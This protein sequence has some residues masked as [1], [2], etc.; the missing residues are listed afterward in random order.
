LKSHPEFDGRGVVIAILDT[1]VDPGAIGLQITSENKPKIIDIYDCSGSGDVDIT[2]VAEIKESSEGKIEIKGLT[3]R[4]LA[5]NPAWAALNPGGS[6]RVGVKRLFELYPKPLLRRVKEER[7]KDWDA[8]QHAAKAQCRT[9]LVALESDAAAPAGN[10]TPRALAQRRKALED[11]KETLA[12]LEAADKDYDDPGPISDCVAWRDGEGQWW[13][14]VDTSCA[15][16]LSQAEAMTNYRTLRQYRSFDDLA[17]LN[18]CLNFWDDGKVMS[19][20]ADA[21][22]HGTHVAGITAGYFP[23]QPELNGIAPGAQLVSL[24]IGDS[25]LGS[26]ETGVGLM[27][28]LIY[29]QKLKVDLINMSYG[30]AACV[31]NSG[32]FVRLSEE[33]VNKH[34][35]MY[36]CSAGNNGPALTTVG[37]PGGTSSAMIGVGAYVAPSMMRDAYSMRQLVQGCNYTW[38]SVGPAIDGDWGVNLMAPGG[39]IAPICN[40]TLSKSGLKNGTSMSSPNAC[41]NVA[42]LV[43]ALKQRGLGVNVNQVRRSLE[44]TCRMLPNRHALIQGHGLLQV[45][46]AYSDLCKWA[47]ADWDGLRFQV[48]VDGTKRGLYLRQPEQ[49]RAKTDHTVSVSPKFHEDAPNDD[50]IKFEMR[51]KLMT[52]ASYVTIP[53][54]LVLVHGGKGFG[55]SIDPTAL[56]EGYHFCTINGYNAD[57]L[58][59][60]PVF[61]VPITVIRPRANPS[62]TPGAPMDLGAR[63]YGPGTTT[64]DFLVPPEGATWVNIIVTDQRPLPPATTEADSGAAK[65]GLVPSLGPDRSAEDTV[66]VVCLHTIQMMPQS[67]YRDFEFQKYLRVLPGQTQVVSMRVEPGFTLEVCLSQWWS[68]LPTGPVTASATFRGVMPQPRNL[69]IKGGCRFAPVV[70]R[71]ELAPE[72]VSPSVTLE[73]WVQLVPPKAL[74]AISPLG[75]RDSLPDGKKI[76]QLVLEYAISN[77]EAGQVTPRAPGLNGVLYEAEF[78]HQFFMVFD[79]KK[80]YLGCGDAWPSAVKLPKGDLVLRMQVRHDDPALL[81]K[82]EGQ[83]LHLERTLSSKISLSVYPTQGAAATGG[84]A[85]GSGSLPRGGATVC[86]VGEPP[87]DKWPKGAKA[88][89]LLLGT[90]TYAKANA[91][92]PGEGKR[93]KGFPVVYSIPPAAPSAP[94]VPPVEAKDTRTEVEKVEEAIRDLKVK[95]LSDLAGKDDFMTLYDRF[96]AEYPDHLPLLQTKLAHL[97]SDKLRKDNLTQIVEVAEGIIGRIDQGKLAQHFGTNIDSDDPEAVKGRKAME[98]E[99]GALISALASKARAVGDLDQQ[100][101]GVEESKEDTSSDKPSTYEEAM[102]ELE[103][104]ESL[105]KDQHAKLVIARDQKSGRHGAVL[106]LVSKLLGSSCKVIGKKELLSLRKDTYATLGWKHL[107]DYD[108][109]WAIISEPKMYAMF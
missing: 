82:Y 37:A 43:S 68:S 24:K 71:A 40:W 31:A 34:G 75:E 74:G 66:R 99:K 22:D 102:A 32:R 46:A 62:S 36:L 90:A 55:F 16:D 20:V 100:A 4:T 38:S 87:A 65:M 13:G 108:E 96:V 79:D 54:S 2:T 98:K 42:L 91:S 83:I 48:Q 84:K 1:G 47:G 94:K 28:A 33:I 63:L 30:E 21:G 14:A 101:Q 76:Y 44:N 12:Q 5:L 6:W 3:G 56:P 26:M 109:S 9:R 107:V 7:R 93:P 15:G 86:R 105:N 25:R 69:M 104:W 92:L 51:I 23:D 18:Y 73:N 57:A 85:F 78:E 58:E 77:L 8:A 81:K 106:K 89:D 97:D 29:A 64:R 19:I 11:M 72:E 70:L 50:K 10:S 52:A 59:R 103:K 80:K 17:K 27:R 49:T 95:K 45:A 88:G 35:I 41:G 39:A 53:D 61:E 60:G 67:P